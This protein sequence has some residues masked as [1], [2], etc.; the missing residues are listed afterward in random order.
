M[1]LFSG[2]I[3]LQY[4]KLEQLSTEYKIQEISMNKI[5]VSEHAVN[6]VSIGSDLDPE[7]PEYKALEARREKLQLMEKKLDQEMLRY[8]TLLK[9]INTEIE[10]AQ[11]IVDSSIKRSFNYGNSVS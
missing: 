5:R 11:K 6:L 4:L 3:R 1:G 8:Q 7:S 10:S 2:L 9:A